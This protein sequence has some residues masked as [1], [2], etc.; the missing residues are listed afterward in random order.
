[1][2]PACSTRVME[3]L[4]GA[5][6]EELCSLMEARMRTHVS[7]KQKSVE[8]EKAPVSRRPPVYSPACEPSRCRL[9]RSRIHSPFKH[10]A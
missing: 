4:F 2:N 8:A 1:M 5:A 9:R 7:E 10:A 6:S 3:Q